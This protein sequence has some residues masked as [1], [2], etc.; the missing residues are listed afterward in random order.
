MFS[1]RAEIIQKEELKNILM[2]IIQ[3]LLFLQQTLS[4][5]NVNC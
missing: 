2:Q 5:R 3:S 1:S 4:L